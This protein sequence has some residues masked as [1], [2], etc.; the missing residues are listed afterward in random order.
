MQKK[1]IFS[2]ILYQN[3]PLNKNLFCT[4]II[5]TQGKIYNINSQLLLKLNKLIERY[6]S[7]SKLITFLDDLFAYIWR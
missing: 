3:A 6:F 2:K 1:S 7:K 4:K 5:L